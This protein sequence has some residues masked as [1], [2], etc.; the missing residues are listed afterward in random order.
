[1][2][3]YK[4]ASSADSQ[5]GV[6]PGG[7]GGG[8]VKKT[9]RGE[10]VK[11]VDEWAAWYYGYSMT[12]FQTR[13]ADDLAQDF[14]VVAKQRGK[15]RYELLADLI[16]AATKEVTA[17]GWGKHPFPNGKRLKVNAAVTAREGEDR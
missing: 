12:L 15:S 3:R 2:F 16:K 8:W 4:P 7:S 17:E 11:R 9:V 13:V 6:F 1:M 5:N 10:G 14:D